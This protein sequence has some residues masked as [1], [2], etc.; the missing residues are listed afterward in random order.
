MVLINLYLKGG[1]KTRLTE[2]EENEIVQW[3]IKNKD[4]K[5]NEA[6]HLV[7]DQVEKIFEQTQRPNPF[8]NG[9]PS[10]D[11]WYDFLSRH[12]QIM[13]SKP[14]W[15]RR[16]KVNDQYIKDVQSGQL[17][18][19]KFRRALL[20]AIQY[21][22]SLTDS[23]ENSC[24]LE[25]DAFSNETSSKTSKNKKNSKTALK[26]VKIKTKLLQNSKMISTKMTVLAQHKSQNIFIKQRQTMNSILSSFDSD[27]NQTELNINNKNLVINIY[28]YI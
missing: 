9:K 22:R 19:T 17:K 18:C 28:I 27:N 3:L 13:A 7:F 21:I 26:P 20:S 24:N 16:G 2:I 23:N 5:Y 14:D 12:P 4:V 6:I 1:K 25:T 15:L 8:S 11:W 10:M